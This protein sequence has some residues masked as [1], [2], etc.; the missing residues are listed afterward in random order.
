MK[1]FGTLLKGFQGKGSS[2]PAATTN[3]ATISFKPWN[4]ICIIIRRRAIDEKRGY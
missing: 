1:V 2:Q 3:S 4:F